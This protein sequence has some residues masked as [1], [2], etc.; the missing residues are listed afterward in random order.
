MIH[1]TKKIKFK[2]GKDSNSMIMRKLMYNFLRDSRITTTETR[3]KALKMYL[4]RIISKAKEKTE[5]NKNYLLRYFPDKK[6]ISVLF[7]QV[8]PAFANVNGG[9]VKIVR[10]TQRE[11]DAA[12]M[13]RLLWAHPAVI[14]WS[15]V[16]APKTSV[17]SKKSVTSS[18][19]AKAKS[20]KKAKADK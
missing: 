15:Q 10:L 4:E 7:D 12:M 8:G 5:A 20:D 1:R 11:N 3:A 6:I 9:Y 13:V 19:K 17:K 18:D 16:E 2:D 14:D